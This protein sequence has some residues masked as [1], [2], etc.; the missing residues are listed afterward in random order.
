MWISK[1]HLAIL[2]SFCS[3]QEL[4]PNLSHRFRRL[5]NLLHVIGSESVYD[6]DISVSVNDDGNN[7]SN[8]LPL[9][10]FT[11][12]STKDLKEKNKNRF[13]IDWDKV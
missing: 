10:L 2:A 7:L 12:F 3:F 5:Q 11:T 8:L 4:G 1:D 9:S 13:V 6:S